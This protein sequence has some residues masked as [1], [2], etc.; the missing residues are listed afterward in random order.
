MASENGLKL[1][2]YQK[3]G[4]GEINGEYTLSDYQTDIK[5]IL[6][7]D[8]WILPP[9]KTVSGD[10]YSLRGS[11]MLNIVY[12]GTDGKLYSASFPEDYSIDVKVPSG[13]GEEP[14]FDLAFV[15]DEGFGIRLLSPR[16]ISI[17]GRI[18]A[19]IYSFSD[20]ERSECM[21]ENFVPDGCEALTESLE[22]TSAAY[23][24]SEVM[25]LSDEYISELHTDS[26]RIIYADGKAFV[27]SAVSKED[28]ADLRGELWIDILSSD[29]AQN[30]IPKLQRRKITFEKTFSCP[31]LTES[32]RLFVKCVPTEITVTPGETGNSVRAFCLAEIYA[33]ESGTEKVCTDIY[34]YKNESSVTQNTINTGKILLLSSGNMSINAALGGEEAGFSGGERAILANAKVKDAAL[35]FSENGKAALSGNCEFKI[36]TADDSAENMNYEVKSV[37][38]PFKYEPSEKITP[39]ESGEDFFF[40][41]DIIPERAGV[42]FDGERVG[43]DCELCISLLV[44]ERMK[45][46]VVSDIVPGEELVR[47]EKSIR[48]VYPEKSDTL[49]S[50]AKENNMPISSICEANR[51]EN[52]ENPMNSGLILGCKYLIM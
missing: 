31:G 40:V 3:E 6:Y 30:E 47:D 32:S 44:M 42:R 39:P 48:I 28:E 41:A 21:T 46:S 51:I 25:E 16:K 7:T 22:Y 19:N 4:N 37:S 15:S 5:K 50:I 24:G 36:L 52:P 26:E 43:V 20:A 38:L 27:T 13:S 8:E 14:E 29:D 10:I 18:C 23:F 34:S 49:W 11:I 33:L 2:R 45:H 35:S 17:K 1:L 9:G 12:L